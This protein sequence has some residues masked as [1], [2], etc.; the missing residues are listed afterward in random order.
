MIDGTT[1]SSDEALASEVIDLYVNQ[2]MSA[3]KIAAQKNCSSLTIL[4]IL[5]AQGVK[6]RRRGTYETKDL[7]VD[8]IQEMYENGMSIAKIASKHGV[9]PNTIHYHMKQ[10]GI[11]TKSNRK[12]SEK[13][14]KRILQEYAK[15][16]TRE[17]VERLATDFGVTENAI[18][19]HVK[20]TGR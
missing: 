16:P 11:K 1:Y 17:T 20:K 5:R 18:R 13:D 6:I 9:N 7:D 15:M 12:L 3:P 2:K 8:K 19:Y 10:N 4:N 14:V